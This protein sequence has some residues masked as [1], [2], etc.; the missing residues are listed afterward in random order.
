MSRIAYDETISP[1][2]RNSL[3]KCYEA[4]DSR[5]QYSSKSRV[6]LVAYIGHLPLQSP[7]KSNRKKVGVH[8]EHS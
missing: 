5:L 3:A 2:Q 8:R 7:K 4:M 1:S 6:R